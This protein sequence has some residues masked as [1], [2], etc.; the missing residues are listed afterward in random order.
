MKISGLLFILFFCAL[1]TYAQSVLEIKSPDQKISF[2]LQHKMEAE[3]GLFYSIRYGNQAVVEWS[4]LGITC[5]GDP[6]NKQLVAVASATQ[7]HDTTW[8]PVYGE[9]D[10]IRDHYN[11]SVVNIT[12]E[13]RKF[14]VLQLIVRAYDS[15]IAFRYKFATNENGGPYLHITGEST[16]FNFQENTR[17]WFTAR[18]Q[19]LHQILPL[20]NWPDESD[21]PLTLDLPNGL[22]A[23]LAEAQM[24]NFSRTKF[25]LNP[26]KGNSI[27]TSIYGD[28]DE[29]APFAAPWRVVMVAEKAGDLLANNDLILNLNPSC[30]IADPSWIKPGKVMREV[31]LSTSGAKKLVDFAV[32]RNIKYIHFD[33]GWYGFENDYQA[34]ATT[35]T[36]DPR[37]NPKGDLDLQEAIRYAKSKGIGVFVYVNQRA[38][39]AQLDTILPLYQK[40]G[41]AGIKFG[42]V[43]VGSHRWTTWLHEAVKK[44]AKYQLMVDIH[45]EY[46]PTGFSRTYPNLM[47]QEGIRG[48]EEMPDAVNNTVLPFTRFVAGAADYTFCYFYRKELGH[49]TRHIQNT[50]AHQLAL[51]VIYYSPLQWMYWYDKPDDYQNEP[52]LAFWDVLPTTWNDTKVLNGEIGKYITVARRNADKWFVGSIT[53]TDARNLKVP[54]DF[55][56]PEKKYEATLYFDDDQVATRTRVGISKQKVDAKTVL[57]IQLKASG[58]QAILI[59]PIN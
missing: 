19:S 21:R 47:T 49:P 58:G 48:N 16:E 54:L 59:E 55:L 32:A 33:A 34:D 40:W 37:R 52:E 18:A 53:N 10:R 11:E 7:L 29:I 2:T 8:T 5:N 23:C 57:N 13:N 56:E 12:R 17:A 6:W 24:T 14:P 35:V 15:G 46:R 41:V 38:L 9:R 50:S 28:V 31:T 51:P 26:N 20:K 3:D 30:Q 4:K 36:V 22:F 45:D 42:F 44:C 25:K 39:A 1:T 27:L 43:Q